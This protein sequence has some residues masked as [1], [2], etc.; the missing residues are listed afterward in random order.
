MNGWNEMEI[1]R[2]SSH[3][4]RGSNFSKYPVQVQHRPCISIPHTTPWGVSVLDW[5]SAVR[6]IAGRRLK[7]NP[8]V[9]LPATGSTDHAVALALAGTA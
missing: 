3:L 5:I 6:L 2:V 9:V 1:S 4:G 7:F 8:R